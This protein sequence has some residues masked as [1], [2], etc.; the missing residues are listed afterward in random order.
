MNSL[1]QAQERERSIQEQWR[2]ASSQI[3]SFEANLNREKQAR[4]VAETKVEE[5]K[6]KNGCLE[7]SIRQQ[8]KDHEEQYGEKNLD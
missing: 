1:A 7:E 8:L 3:I 6:G 5:L 2:G 4:L